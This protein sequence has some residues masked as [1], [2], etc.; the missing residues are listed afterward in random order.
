MELILAEHNFSGENSMILTDF[1]TRFVREADIQEVSEAQAFVALQSFFK[2]YARSKYEA[3]V[4]M[5]SAEK[6][7]VS[8]RP[9]AVQHL[10]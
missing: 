8:S 2:G 10:L 1:L 5:A 7:G 9:E 6:G 3:G 4:E